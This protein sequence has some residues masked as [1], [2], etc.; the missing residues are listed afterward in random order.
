MS[1]KSLPMKDIRGQEAAKVR[2]QIQ[3]TR[4]DIRKLRTRAV[5]QDLKDVRAIRSARQT[6]ARLLTRQRELAV[7]PR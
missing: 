1:P 7:T 6:L 5:A 3:T 2:E 4:A